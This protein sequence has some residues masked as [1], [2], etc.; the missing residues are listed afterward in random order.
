M[1][2]TQ[3]LRT[4]ISKACEPC[5]QQKIKCSGE[6]PCKRCLRLSL[7]CVVRKV[8]RQRQRQPRLQV[9]T[10]S[11]CKINGSN[12]IFRIA[13]KS[14]RIRNEIA[15]S[16]VSRTAVYGPTSAVAVLHL[17]ALG[18][19]SGPGY[20]A[21]LTEE[22]SVINSDLS[23]EDFN[24]HLLALGSSLPLDSAV[25]PPPLCLTIIPKQLLDEIG[26]FDRAYEILSHAQGLIC[27][28]G[29]HLDPRAQT[30]GVQRLLRTILSVDIYICIAVGR[31]S[32]LT[33]TMSLSTHDTDTDSPV[34][35]FVSGLF[36]IMNN[37]LRAQQDPDMTFD[38]LCDLVWTTHSELE[39]FW[40]E[41]QPVLQFAYVGL[42]V[43]G[44]VT[45]EMELH[46]VLHQYAVNNSTNLN[47]STALLEPEQEPA[48]PSTATSIRQKGKRSSNQPYT[49]PPLSSIIKQ[50]YT[51]A[52][53]IIF[54]LSKISRAGSLL[55]AIVNFNLLS[56]D[57]PMNSFFLET[58]CLSLVCCGLWHGHGHGH[59]TPDDEQVWDALD[60]GIQCLEALQNQKIACMRLAAVRAILKESGLQRRRPR[61]TLAG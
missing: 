12:A 33:S 26:N 7:T 55:K 10:S 35:K 36:S 32:L 45:E 37:T 29:Y 59:D 4:H 16:A 1:E 39:S 23:L 50:I 14:V 17:I 48:Q 27:T 21:F 47:R 60:E 19:S 2:P 42:G 61:S 56:L 28:A 51:C 22:K 30:P 53:K 31:P 38:R 11:Q 34:S 5:R 44:G 41:H 18:R 49:Q 3:S 54:T 40:A 52:S 57:L 20:T 6:T 43:E 8:T 15:G 9:N 46:V 58:S 13:L 24:Y 25:L